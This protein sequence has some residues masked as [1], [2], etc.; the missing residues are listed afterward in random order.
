M[1]QPELLERVI[2]VLEAAAI[3]YMMTGS[4]AS[5]I[6]GEPRLTHDIDLVVEITPA[7]AK[8]LLLAFP[9]PDYYLDE[10]SILSAISSKSQF[11]LLDSTGGDKVDFWILT[12][13]PFDK[14]RFARRYP[15]EINGRTIFVSAPEDTILM[16]LKWC[17]MS[18]GSEKQF[19]DARSVYELQHATLDLPHIEQWAKTLQLD[20]L[21]ERLKNEA[22][23]V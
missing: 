5:S 1:S 13:E 15:Q 7:A 11:N 18:G 22:D 19:A 23:P 20:S 9:G 8:S 2:D 10:Y 12:D 4:Y 14:T 3:P 17:E 21:W 16:K 6:Q